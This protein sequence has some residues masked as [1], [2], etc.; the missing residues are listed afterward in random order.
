[1]R[2]YLIRHG[3]SYVNLPDWPGGDAD[4]GLTERGHRQAKALAAWLPNHLPEIH[5]L[6]TSTM[7]RTRETT[8]YL[9]E[10]YPNPVQADDRIR[11]IGNN[12]LDHTAWPTGEAPSTEEFVDFWSSERPFAPVATR[13]GG[14]SMMHFKVR[15]GLFLEEA[16]VRHQD[17]TVVVV[18]HGGV[19]DMVFDYAFGV[20]PWRRCEIWTVNTGITYFEHVGH[21]GRET[22]RLHYQNRVEHLRDVALG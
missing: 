12:R 17:Q 4:L 9:A 15:V 2:L 21:P 11:E 19:V 16:L 20:G 7:L 18:C 10:V 3:E 1:V 22:W 14:E 6:Y 13:E 5:A 8:A